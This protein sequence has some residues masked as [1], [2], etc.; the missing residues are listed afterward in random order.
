LDESPDRAVDIIPSPGLFS[1]FTI[2]N[3]TEHFESPVIIFNRSVDSLKI[4]SVLIIHGVE[5]GCPEPL[6]SVVIR[7]MKKH[8]RI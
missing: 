2:L 7:G 6:F 4:P 8:G 5:I 3:A 1:D